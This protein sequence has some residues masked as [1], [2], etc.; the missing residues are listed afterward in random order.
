VFS[1][2]AIPGNEVAINR[3][4][5]AMV[6]RGVRVITDRDRL[7]H[8]SGHPRRDELRE[9]Y[10]WIN[11]SIAVPVHGEAMHLA[12]HAELAADLG[13]PI[14]KVI[15]DGDVLRLAPGPVETVDE[16]EAGRIYR[17]GS[18]IG[19][20]EAMGIPGRRRLSFAGH[21]AVAIVL[22][23]RGEIAADPEI[24]LTGLPLAD[25]DGRPFQDSVMDSVNGALDS[26]P[27]PRRRD[28]EVVREAVRRAVRA[29]VASAWG[30]KPNCAVL[31]SVL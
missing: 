6:A 19:N 18:L 29:G 31:V 28:P 14:V 4:I 5:N 9:M 3:I 13:V 21:V 25:R 27:R 10:G 12:A 11:P 23:D 30:K 24:E 22:D 2:R 20:L 15:G 7:V 17:D 26:I 1:S 8:V 16:V